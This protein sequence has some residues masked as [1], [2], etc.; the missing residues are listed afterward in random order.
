MDFRLQAAKIWK[1]SDSF[2]QGVRAV[3][4][5]NSCSHPGSTGCDASPHLHCIRKLVFVITRVPA[6]TSLPPAWFT[7][8]SSRHGRSC[9]E[10]LWSRCTC[11][12]TEE[13]VTFKDDAC[14]LEYLFVWYEALQ[15]EGP[16]SWSHVIESVGYLPLPWCH[17]ALTLTLFFAT[18][19]CRSK[20]SERLFLSQYWWWSGV[21][22]C[23]FMKSY[24]RIHGATNL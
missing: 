1:R 24:M 9:I 8:C 21:N 6:V 17:I 2:R 4:G 5:N 13:Y 7:E 22:G 23:E 10:T 14:V 18:L 19:K 16:S 15:L 11:I 20:L 3:S 12:E